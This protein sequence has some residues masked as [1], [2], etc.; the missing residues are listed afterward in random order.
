MS[1]PPVS[2][3]VS[4]VC[5]TILSLSSLKTLIKISLYSSYSSL[6]SILKLNS[7]RDTLTE[8]ESLKKETQKETPGQVARYLSDPSAHGKGGVAGEVAALINGG[9][10]VRA[11]GSIPREE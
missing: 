5:N 3:L 11:R 9:E 1:T 7:A 2:Q 8:R 4:S 6:D 10:G